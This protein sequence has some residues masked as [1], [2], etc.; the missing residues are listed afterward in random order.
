MESTPS[1]SQDCQSNLQDS[2]A[3]NFTASA[4]STLNRSNSPINN[5]AQLEDF[6]CHADM[7]SSWTIIEPRVGIPSSSGEKISDSLQ[8]PSE[9]E[10]PIEIQKESWWSY[11]AKSKLQKGDPG[12]GI[13]KFCVHFPKVAH[14]LLFS[15]LVGRPIILFGTSKYR[16]KV[17]QIISAL[18]PFVPCYPMK[19]FKIFRWHQGILVKAHLDG[20]H[21]L[22][23]LCIPERLKIHDLINPRD[24]NSIT[25]FDVENRKIFGPA[26]SGKYLRNFETNPIQKHFFDDLSLLCFLGS[27]LT[28]IEAEVYM[29]KAMQCEGKLSFPKIMKELDLKSSDV[30]IS[31]YLSSLVADPP[32]C[33]NL[34]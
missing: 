22:I 19:T 6:L 18:I 13:R 28:D 33:I 31:K 15:I 12:Y 1:T 4:T 8:L 9:T 32:Q 5:D 29:I 25:L 17:S 24:Q 20:S 23:G 3:S 10:E 34:F 11:G 27:I 2:V 26:Y 16:S 21:K 30:E 14:H 7:N